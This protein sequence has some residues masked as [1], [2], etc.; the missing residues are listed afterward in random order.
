MERSDPT[1]GSSPSNP[2]EIEPNPWKPG[3]WEPARLSLLD[4][5]SVTVWLC[6]ASIL[7]GLDYLLPSTPEGQTK[8]LT[9]VEDALPIPGWGIL[10]SGFGFLLAL[11]VVLK[12]H[13]LVYL[14]HW[15]LG[16]VT[17][18]L[19]VGLG[20]EYLT[21][22]WGDG[23]RSAGTLAVVAAFYLIIAIRTGWEPKEE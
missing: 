21:R 18:A 17:A 22:P 14:S 15:T 13:R 19:T 2:V 3:S 8:A 6:L 20:A 7:R 11:S 12:I 4:S 5:M 16:V 9:V 1:P 10:F 23:I